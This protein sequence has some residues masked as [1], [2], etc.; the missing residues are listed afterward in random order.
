MELRPLELTTFRPEVFTLFEQHPPLLTAGNRDKCNTMTIGWC[1]LGRTW[2]MPTC[3]VLVRPERY[4]YQ[5]MEEQDYFTVSL[6]DTSYNPVIA[7][8]G[9]R[10]GRDADKIAENGLTLCYGAGD[11]PYFAQAELVFV[12]KKIYYTD[13]TR[14]TMLDPRVSKFYEGDG[15]H[16]VYTGEVVEA[17][18][19]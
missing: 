18:Q 17:Y 2:R 12:C 8:C 7:D 9:K 6:M 3:T 1:Q 5:F 13:L 15:L 11:A 4:T 10:S 19:K 16:R 14:E